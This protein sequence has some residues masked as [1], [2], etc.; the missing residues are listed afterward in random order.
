MREKGGPLR[1]VFVTDTFI[2]TDMGGAERVLW[3]QARR[4]AKRGHQVRVVAGCPAGRL[5]EPEVLE[6]VAIRYFPR[7]ERPTAAHLLGAYRACRAALRSVGR[8]GAVD[9]LSAHLDRK[10]VV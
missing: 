1:L 6:G 7:D 9:L 5:R 8:E 2:T 3:E 4:L 10:S